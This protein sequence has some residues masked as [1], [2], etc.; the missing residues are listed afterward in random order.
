[1]SS[2]NYKKRLREDHRKLKTNHCQRDRRKRIDLKKEREN[3]EEQTLL[4]KKCVC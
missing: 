1:M 4:V 3:N 2:K